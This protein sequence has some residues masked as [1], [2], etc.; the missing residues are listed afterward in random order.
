MDYIRDPTPSTTPERVRNEAQWNECNQRVLESPDYHRAPHQVRIAQSDTFIPP[1]PV[2]PN[3]PA[4]LLPLQ[5]ALSDTSI[6]PV[7]AS[8]YPNL[9][10]DLSEQY[11][12]VLPLE[13]APSE[14]QLTAWFKINQSNSDARNTTYQNF[15]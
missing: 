5:I 3:L 13:I 12:A 1:A 11:A 15:P 8:V 6:L 9:P 14:T 10:A 2:Y 4:D 7:P